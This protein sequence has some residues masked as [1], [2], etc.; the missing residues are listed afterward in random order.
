MEEFSYE[1]HDELGMHAR[2]A[3]ML[4]RLAAG[5]KSNIMIG[6]EKG[7]A[8]AKR[9]IALM[10]LGIQKDT[11]VR[12][13]VCGDDEKAAAEAVQKFMKENL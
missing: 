7:E 2:P 3:G 1:I 9:L 12:V 13:T 6:C 8:D 11:E 10:K 5:Y 4:A